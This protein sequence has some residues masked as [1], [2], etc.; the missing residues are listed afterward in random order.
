M[1]S[2]HV[3]ALGLSAFFTFTISL[4]SITRTAKVPVKHVFTVSFVL[5]LVLLLVGNGAATLLAAGTLSN[6]TGQTSTENSEPPDAGE[7]VDDSNEEEV[8][9]GERNRG[10]GVKFPGPI[11][12]WAAFLGVF[13][14]QGVL[15]RINITMFGQGVLTIEDWIKKAEEAAI[16]SANES[17]TTTTF[18]EAERI[19]KLLAKLP[20][21]E[22]NTH[23]ATHLGSDVLQ[24]LETA[25]A[26][27]N[28]DPELLKAK[29]LASQ[30]PREAKAVI[31]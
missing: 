16:A 3:S 2:T 30:K 12:M 26:A 20:A 25:A 27:N 13:G 4:V 23:V 19:A 6:N 28:A 21:S 15:T 24:E 29:A 17:L 5:Y 9:E 1:E 10:Y 31:G 7:A 8:P 11:W 14:F 18:A 22:L